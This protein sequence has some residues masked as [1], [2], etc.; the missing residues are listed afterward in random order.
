MLPLALVNS[1][2]EFYSLC[3]FLVVRHYVIAKE[4]KFL[5]ISYRVKKVLEMENNNE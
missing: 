3:K 1:F 4:L 5:V 2:F